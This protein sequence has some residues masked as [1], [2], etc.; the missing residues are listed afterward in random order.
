MNKDERIELLHSKLT[1]T[2]HRERLWV[3]GAFEELEIFRAPTNLLYL[4]DD[5]RRFR[6]EGQAVGA[7]L[8]RRLDPSANPDDEQSIISLLLDREPWVIEGDRVVGRPSKDTAALLNDWEARGQERPLWVRP[9]GLVT[10]GN[11]RLAM[12]RREQATRGEFGEWVQVI[13]FPEES[14]DDEILF[15]LEAREQLTEGFKKRYSDINMLLTL[16]D[17]AVL[18]HIDWDDP[19]SIKTTA[20]HIQHLV[21]SGESYAE[22]QLYAIRYM[23]LFLEYVEQRGQYH[24]L[25]GRV[26]RFREVGKTMKG[27]RDDDAS[28]EESMLSVMFAGIQTEITHDDIR[29]LRK[30]LKTDPEKFDNVVKDVHELEDETEEEVEFTDDEID[31]D[32]DEDEDEDEGEATRAKAPAAPRYPKRAVKRTLRLAV[33]GVRDAKDDDR[34]GGIQLAAQ[35]LASIEPTELAPMLEDGAAGNKLREAIDSIIAWAESAKQ[36]VGGS[37]QQS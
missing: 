15:D 13:V 33:Q 2:G 3:K 29:N 12:I 35:R 37:S 23:D 1:K 6:T 28:R 4:N 30:L 25:Q 36:V 7:Q 9:D 31:L 20:A 10:N 32:E 19:A 22:I 24:L 8:G 27:V 16:R 18:E 5:N 34:A 21:S 14:Y 11:R 17:A 26:E